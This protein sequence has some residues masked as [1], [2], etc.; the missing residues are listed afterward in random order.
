MLLYEL[1][2]SAKDLNSRAMGFPPGSVSCR[3]KALRHDHEVRVGL[4]GRFLSGFVA[5]LKDSH[6]LVLE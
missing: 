4:Q 1:P 2:S 3:L 5:I 6:E